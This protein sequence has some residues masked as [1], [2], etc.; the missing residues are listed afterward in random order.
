[1]PDTA[2]PTFEAERARRSRSVNPAPLLLVDP[3]AS[4]PPLLVGD[5]AVEMLLC[6][7]REASSAAPLLRPKELTR[8]M[9][10]PDSSGV[11]EAAAA[12]GSRLPVRRRRRVVL[13][14]PSVWLMLSTRFAAE[15]T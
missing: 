11:I 7:A 5:G 2:A 3:L 4:F 13:E 10:L 14:L 1:M 9:I 15:D 6:A 8:F 12:S